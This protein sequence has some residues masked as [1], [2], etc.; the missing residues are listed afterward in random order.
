M[1]YSFKILREEF[2]KLGIILNV[3]K[4]KELKLIC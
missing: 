1:K 3:D 2:E 4:M